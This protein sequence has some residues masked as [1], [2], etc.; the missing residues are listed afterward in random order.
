MTSRTVRCR[1]P[2]L[3]SL[4]DVGRLEF[5]KGLAFLAMLADHLDLLVFGRA[6][7]LLHELGRF[8]L[9]VFALTFGLGLARSSDARAAGLRLL[10]PGGLAQIAWLFAYPAHPLNVL[11]VFAALAFVVSYAGPTVL[12]FWLLALALL[13]L[14]AVG[15]G[16]LFTVALVLGGYAAGLNGRW[17]PLL[18]VGATWVAVA[19]SA[20]ALAAVLAV[21]L[22]R[23]SWPRPPRARGWLAWGYAAHLHVLALLPAIR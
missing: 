10:V 9:P 19:P 5:V 20:G 1:E 7:P 4:H 3:P 6:V 17:W 11:L 21:A 8:A 14:D 12:R 18:L 13:A 23:S 16:G 2:W 22:W 15:E